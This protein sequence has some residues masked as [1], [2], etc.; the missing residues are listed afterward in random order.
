LPETWPQLD[1]SELGWIYPMGPENLTCR[2]TLEIFNF[3]R[4]EYVINIDSLADHSGQ[5]FETFGNHKHFCKKE[6][7]MDL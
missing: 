5:G 7:N 6:S 3:L 2:E 1:M 4:F